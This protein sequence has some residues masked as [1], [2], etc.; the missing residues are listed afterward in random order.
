MTRN[1][2][3]IKLIV[4]DYLAA[5]LAWILF[6]ALRKY[7]LHEM[8]E[9][10]SFFLLGSAVMIATFWLLLYT[11]IGQ[12]RD[13]FRKSRVKEIT[14]LAQ[15]SFLGAIIIF[16]ALLL[17]DE[18]VENYRSYYKTISTYFLLH[19]LITGIFRTITI[20]SIKKLIR[21][22]KIS[23]NTL[24]VG[25][26]A[27]AREVYLELEKNNRHLGLKILG[28]LH[29]FQAIETLFVNELK[30][31]G[32]Y[33][34]LPELI[35]KHNIEEV[36]IAIEPSEHKK[37]EEILGLMEGENVRISILPDLYQI[38]LGSVKVNHLF[39]TP[40]IEIK[41]NLMPVWQEVLKRVIDVVASALFL[42]IFFPVYAMI[43]AMVK[44]SS[45]G[46]VF[47]KQERIG[48]HG[49]PFYIYKFRSMFI[50]AEKLGP[51][52]SS[53]YDPRI[54]SW[55]RFMRKVRLDEL[56]QFWNVI[57]GDMS[58]VGPRPERQFFIDQIVKIA[59]HY[60]HLHRV[61]PGITSLGQVK[62]GYASSVDEMVR[63]LKFDILYIENMSL[64]MDF[65][66]MLYTI[67]IIVEGRGK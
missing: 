11:L 26:N 29:V 62:Y 51:S 39:G 15:I 22:G 50:D 19:F 40:L 59:P 37:I 7:I 31:L 63:R 55:G 14:N 9:G 13:I 32:Y 53:D 3:K 48:K 20:T 61:R 44:L 65:R 23:F 30:N 38:L 42:L 56:P 27:N 12:Y 67:K 21:Q 58:L 60:K 64:A 5:L 45:P 24:I 10:I 57:I 43:A 49:K 18:G 2:Q 46:P 41:Q 47:Y 17:D 36:I 35:K 34:K 8:S 4:A 16:F 25:S 1:F 66:V 33:Q 52:L 6:Y 28:Y 54:T